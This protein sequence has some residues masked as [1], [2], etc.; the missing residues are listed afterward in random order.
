MNGANVD[1]IDAKKRREHEHLSI[2]LSLHS[3]CRPRS[4]KDCFGPERGEPSDRRRLDKRPKAP[5]K[6]SLFALSPKS[7]QK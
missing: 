1:Q 4:A 7:C 5:G 2:Y 3:H 6:A